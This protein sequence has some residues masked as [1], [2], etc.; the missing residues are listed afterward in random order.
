MT[1][2][3]TQS[4]VSKL[5]D[6]LR[7]RVSSIDSTKGE[8]E[9]ATCDLQ[10]Q[11]AVVTPSAKPKT[12]LLIAL[13]SRRFNIITFG[14]PEQQHGVS[15]KIRLCKDHDIVSSMFA[16]AD[17]CQ[18]CIRDCCHLGRYSSELLRL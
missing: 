5:I 18:N 7:D 3:E 14:V 8:T 12:Q 1:E 16:H 9:L 11:T 6:D 17:G 13:D 2:S 4:S 10:A 15:R